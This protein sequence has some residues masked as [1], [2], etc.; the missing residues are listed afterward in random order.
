ML[1]DALLSGA[2]ADQDRL[3]AAV[4]IAKSG[5]VAKTE[6]TCIYVMA[7]RM[8]GRVYVGQT[9]NMRRRVGAHL[10]YMR[11]GRHSAPIQNDFAD[12]GGGS[13]GFAVVHACD[14]SDLDRLEREYVSMAISCLDCY[15]ISYPALNSSRRNVKTTA[16]ARAK[17]AKFVEWLHPDD[18]AAL[19][20]HAALLAKRRERKEKQK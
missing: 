8:T 12:H 6:L 11:T 9:S 19:R 10:S 20:A 13:F 16:A 15:N 1:A 18:A 7:N 2:V 5:H 4:Q 3:A 14:E 17:M